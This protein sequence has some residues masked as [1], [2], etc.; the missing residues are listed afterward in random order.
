MKDELDTYDP[1]LPAEMSKQANEK[2]LL[3]SELQS[4]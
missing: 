4:S 3:E 1:N 2:Q